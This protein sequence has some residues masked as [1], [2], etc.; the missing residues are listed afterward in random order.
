[1]NDSSLHKLS[2]GAL[3]VILLCAA[4]LA[5]PQG[6]PKQIVYPGKGQSADQQAKDEG[7][8]HAW[9]VKSTGIDP[10]GTSPCGRRAATPTSS[11]A[12]RSTS[13]RRRARRRGRR[14]H[15]RGRKQR[16]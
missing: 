10:G 1:M 7:E 3:G 16:R 6:A 8:C 13:A 2:S 11:R 9:S 4:Y 15:W 12:V 14:G 5:Y